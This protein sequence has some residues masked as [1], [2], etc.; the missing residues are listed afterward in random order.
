M[1]RQPLLIALLLG[2]FSLLYVSTIR[3]WDGSLAA[4]RLA[5]VQ[6]LVERHT[7]SIDGSPFMRTVD[8]AYVRG[9]YYSDKAPGVALAAAP[10]YWMLRAVGL[11]FARHRGLVEDLLKLPFAM[12]AGVVPALFFLAARDYAADAR[13]RL[14]VALALGVGTGIF[15]FS[16]LLISH[17]SAAALLLT[18]FY[19][20]IR[21]RDDTRWLWLSGAAAGAAFLFEYPAA[22]PAIAIH[23]EY[24]RRRKDVAVAKA[25]AA[26]VPCVAIAL[27]Y[28][29]AITGHPLDFPYYHVTDWPGSPFQTDANTPSLSNVTLTHVGEAFFFGPQYRLHRPVKVYYQGLFLCSPFFLAALFY[30]RREH[31]VLLSGVAAV[32]VFYLTEV[33]VAGGCTYTNRFLVITLPFLALPALALAR[34]RPW[35]FSA[36]AAAS[37]AMCLLGAVT[38]PVTCATVPLRYGLAHVGP[39]FREYPWRDGLTLLLTAIVVGALLLLNTPAGEAW[40]RRL[41][42]PGCR[43]PRAEIAEAYAE[44]S[45]V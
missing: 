7:L 1:N 26:A 6:S 33:D 38:N 28:N 8:R 39:A 31:L 12:L 21:A 11:S 22:F 41:D 10:L 43:R 45:S 23:L 20:T 44:F 36:L 15:V 27:L 16:G 9:H 4:S 17:S 18:A 19:A 24:L 25:I 32:C 42:E 13:S 5:L 40:M 14:L 35:M 29:L 37:G 2:V 34:R 3:E 30:V